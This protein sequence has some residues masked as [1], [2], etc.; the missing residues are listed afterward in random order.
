MKN[1]C[2]LVSLTMLLCLGVYTLAV[3][4]A[5]LSAD[6]M[7]TLL[8]GCPARCFNSSCP[9]YSE[10]CKC[11]TFEAY[12]DPDIPQIACDNHYV[13]SVPVLECGSKGS[14]DLCNTKTSK[15]ACGTKMDCVCDTTKN[16]CRVAYPA[17]A[18]GDMPQNDCYEEDPD[19]WIMVLEQSLPVLLNHQCPMVETM[20]HSEAAARVTTVS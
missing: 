20:E 5:T 8:A 12:C 10:T 4:D 15:W 17:R 13:A 19:P 9:G 7:S 1:I 6:E 2:V 18:A 3:A 14:L 11:S 16:E